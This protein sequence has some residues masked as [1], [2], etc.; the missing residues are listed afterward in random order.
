MQYTWERYKIHK[1]GRLKYKLEN[2]KMG[3]KK[4]GCVGM[5]L[6]L[7]AVGK[8]QQWLVLNMSMKDE[9][10]LWKYWVSGLSNAT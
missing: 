9:K 1:N 8:I 10:C 7:L 5:D 4:V 3:V 2:N 6:I